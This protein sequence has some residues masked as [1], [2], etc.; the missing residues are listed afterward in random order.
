MEVAM[1]AP[2]SG[3]LRVIRFDESKA[4]FFITDNAAASMVWSDDSQF[5]AFSKWRINKKQ[6][7]CV[8]RVSSMNIDESPDEFRVLEHQAVDLAVQDPRAAQDLDLYALLEVL[9]SFWCYPG[10][11][12]LS[13]GLDWQQLTVAARMNETLSLISPSPCRQSARWSR[14]ISTRQW[15]NQATWTSVST[16]VPA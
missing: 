12:P 11:Q 7:L 8:L 4:E 1:G 3:R 13:A 2:T 10:W 5:L 14:S 15:S 6:I 9:G 16:S